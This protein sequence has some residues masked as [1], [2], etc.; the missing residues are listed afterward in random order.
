MHLHDWQEICQKGAEQVRRLIY[1]PIPSLE[2]FVLFIVV[3]AAAFQESLSSR[4]YIM[5]GS[6]F[7]LFAS[8]M[9]L[10]QGELLGSPVA[11]SL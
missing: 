10:L 2:D 5:M 1:R 8:L 11:C 7:V 4:I 6:K 3:L 9:T